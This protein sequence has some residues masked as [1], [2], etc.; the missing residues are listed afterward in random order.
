ML[1]IPQGLSR[2]MVKV[3]L[4]D[5]ELSPGEDNTVVFKSVSQGKHSITLSYGKVELLKQEA[6]FDW[7][8]GLPYLMNYS[9]PVISINQTYR[10][11]T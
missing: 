7:N 5:M 2:D 11:K 10:G 6:V 1:K 8:N 9:L 3:S 4:D